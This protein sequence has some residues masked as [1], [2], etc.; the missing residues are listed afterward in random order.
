MPSQDE[1]DKKT[2]SPKL[3]EVSQLLASGLTYKQ[4]AKATGVP[5]STIGRW[6]K[7]EAVRTEIES[8]RAEAMEA[9]RQLN[10]EAATE[11]AENL[12]QK[13]RQ[14]A[15]RQEQMI[16][17]GYS[18]GTKAFDLADK[19]LTKASEIFSEDRPIE[20][21]EKLLISSLP[22]LMRAASDTLR[23]TSDVEDKLFALDEM[24]RRLDKWAEFQ[25]ELQNNQN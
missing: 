3:L 13:L 12:Q 25:A 11:C 22:H 21:H 17:Q 10:R 19:M 9:H 24:S 8:L 16:S 7:L 18:F 1:S 14:S 15:K 4:A 6:A 5:R 23:A 2:L 20:P